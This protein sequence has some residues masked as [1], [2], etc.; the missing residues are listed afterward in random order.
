MNC[1]NAIS[2]VNILSLQIHVGPLQMK[3]LEQVESLCSRLKNYKQRT[4]GLDEADEEMMP[5]MNDLEV[6][7][8][9][10]QELFKIRGKVS[11]I[12]LCHFFIISK[13]FQPTLK[14]GKM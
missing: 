8:L 3:Y 6:K 9:G 1:F 10:N 5:Q 2:F 11:T 7:L 13:K 4:L 14:T 12:T